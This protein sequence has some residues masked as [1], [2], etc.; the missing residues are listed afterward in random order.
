[1]FPDCA[2]ARRIDSDL[3]IYIYGDIEQ[4]L[5]NPES[6]N[7]SGFS[8]FSPFIP[9]QNMLYLFVIVILWEQREII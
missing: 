8:T 5:T 3:V 4:N 7:L 1:M 2:E 9:F 6:Q